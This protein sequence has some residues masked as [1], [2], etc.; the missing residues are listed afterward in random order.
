MISLSQ[1]NGHCHTEGG[2]GGTWKASV[3]SVLNLE[4]MSGTKET[5]GNNDVSVVK[6]PGLTLQ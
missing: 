3:L 1:V 2:G 6:R 4:K 5:V